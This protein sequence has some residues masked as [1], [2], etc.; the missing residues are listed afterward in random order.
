LGVIGQNSHAFQGENNVAIPLNVNGQVFEYPVNFDENWGINATGWA[1][2]VTNGMLQ[3]AGGNFPLLANVN[4]GTS[5]GLIAPYLISS[6]ANPATI[7]VVRLAK[8]DA[9]EWR[10]NANSANLP[11]AVNGSDQLTFNGTVLALGTVT[12]IT[13]TAHQI[14]ASSSV[15]AITLSTPQNIDTTSSPTFASLTLTSPLS[16]ANGGTGVA[17]LGNLTDAGTDGIVVTGGT[18]AIITSAS[19]AQH[20]ADTTHNGYLAST[21]WNTFSNKV[22]SITGT[23]NEIIVGGTTTVPVL[24]TPQPIAPSSSPTFASLFTGN[25]S[26]ATPSYSFTNS[27]STGIFLDIQPTVSA[28]AANWNTGS[29]AVS[30]TAHGLYN[31]TPGQLTTTGTLPSGLSLATTYYII[32]LDVNT[33]ALAT[34]NG[35]AQSQ[36][37]IAFTTQGTGTH[38]FTPSSAAT[39]GLSSTGKEMVRVTN[40]QVFIGGSTAV[41][42]PSELIHAEGTGGVSGDFSADI[43]V[44]NTRTSAGR[45]IASSAQVTN[46][47]TSYIVA[48][49]TGDAGT[50]FTGG[51]AFASAGSIILQNGSSQTFS[52]VTG[53]LHTWF[54]NDRSTAQWHFAH[55]SPTATED[56]RITDSNIICGQPLTLTN[57]TTTQINAIAS[58][59]AGMMVYNSTTNHPN[60]YNGTSWVQL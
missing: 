1:Q 54:H 19:L 52:V 49:G 36:I 22:T 15:G 41:T 23:A 31:Q 16:I 48:Y 44:Y 34:T 38:T 53:G 57:L 12:S 29:H 43:I 55:G 59:G 6:T 46:T 60:Y 32:W 2:A 4:F 56:L 27:A 9:I 8:T 58:P 35:N 7:G 13:G 51:P 24:S 37:R 17:S 18:G 30:A 5:F 28:A 26:S 25:N 42:Q 50:L 47:P 45:L 20:V 33:F 10:N 40:G 11:L 14:I 39:L 21:D 3:R